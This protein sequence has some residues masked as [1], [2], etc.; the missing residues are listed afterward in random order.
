MSRAPRG[1]SSRARKKKILKLAK[2]YWG[3][4]SKRLRHARTTVARAKVFA[5]R[6][7]KVRKREFR[8]LWIARI[9]AACREH[10]ITY[11]RFMHGLIKAKIVLDRKM[12]A[13]LAIKEPGTFAKLVV[14][15]Q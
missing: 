4:S 13:D 6:D 3:D 10:N 1:P 2:G 5:Y 11:S 14:A 15:S 7:R 9:N 8:S 12:L